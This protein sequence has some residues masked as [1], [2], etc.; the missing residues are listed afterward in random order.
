[1]TLVQ[2]GNEEFLWLTDT[3]T[4]DYA[5]NLYVAEWIIGGRVTRLAVTDN[6]EEK[7]NESRRNDV[8]D[9]SATTI[10]RRLSLT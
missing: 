4:G 3:K 6:V 8:R 5:G 9:G 1:M 10:E 7:A 2:E